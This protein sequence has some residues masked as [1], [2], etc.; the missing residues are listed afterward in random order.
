MERIVKVIFTT[1]PI[2]TGFVH[3]NENNEITL[4]TNDQGESLTVY[5]SWYIAEEQ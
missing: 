5:D 2:T 1:D 3:I 4:F